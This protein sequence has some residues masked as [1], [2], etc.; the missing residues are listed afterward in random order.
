[1]FE[2][3]NFVEH[4]VSCNSHVAY[5]KIWSRWVSADL[6]FVVSIYLVLQKSRWW[7]CTTLVVVAF[8]I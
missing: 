4:I 3:Y 7:G 6:C 5:W 1:M 2:I 8:S